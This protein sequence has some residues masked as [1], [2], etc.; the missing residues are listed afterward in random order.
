MSFTLVWLWTLFRSLILIALALPLC[1][2]LVRWLRTSSHSERRWQIGLLVLPCLFPELLTGYAYSQMTKLLITGFWT[3]EIWFDLLLFLRV[4]PVGTVL[5]YCSPPSPMS[6]EAWHV[7]RLALRAAEPR[8]KQVAILAW[9]WLQGPARSA[10]FAACGLFLVLFQ[11]FELASLLATT[12]WTVWLFDAQAGGLPLHESLKCCVAPALCTWLVCGT[13]PRRLNGTALHSASHSAGE[14]PLSWMGRGWLW[15]Y[16][17][18]ALLAIVLYPC[19]LIGRETIPGVV[20][21]IHNTVQS[22]G[23][24]QGILSAG[25]YGLIAGWS[26]DMLACW[27]VS[28]NRIRRVRT[29][30]SHP[31]LD[32]YEQTTKPRYWWQRVA[33]VLAGIGLCGSLIIG[34]VIVA[35]FQQVW[36]NS[37]YDTPLPVVLGLIIWLLPRAVLLQG[38][39]MA[40]S[41][42][43]SEHMARLT[44]AAGDR[45]RTDAS[46]Q[47]LWLLRG[48]NALWVR[49]LL[50]YWAYWDLTLPG[51]LTPTGMTSAA[52]RLYIDMHFGRNALLTAKA[53]L[54]LAAPLF[55]LLICWPWLRQTRD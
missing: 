26:A 51:I 31:P 16:L 35:L 43:V 22:R 36:L 9:Y 42:P 39:L 17:L 30:Q 25:G 8:W 41:S 49:L 29:Q 1:G 23:L 7:R 45:P 15:G 37:L 19:L 54:T 47:L 40:T 52:V 6:R 12:S 50:C 27:F 21:L 24:L 14:V 18:V 48:R 32:P 3:R 13:L 34:L 55:L 4:V 11:E 5:W 20:A 46:R 38:M 10:L 44:A 53:G 33:M 28:G 2:F